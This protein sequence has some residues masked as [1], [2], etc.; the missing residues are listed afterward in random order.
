M[1]EVISDNNGAS[2]ESLTE[3]FSCASTERRI[4]FAGFESYRFPR[5]HL[6]FSDLHQCSLKKLG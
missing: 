2:T 6:L 3:L 4:Y 5:E 1:H